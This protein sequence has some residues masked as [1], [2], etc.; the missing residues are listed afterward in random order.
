MARCTGYEVH[1]VV[2]SLKHL[3]GCIII[4]NIIYRY[5]CCDTSG[6]S[7]KSLNREDANF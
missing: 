7:W 3:L 5:K 4:T 6:E 1:G 2:L